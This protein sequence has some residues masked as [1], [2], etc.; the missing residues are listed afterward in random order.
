M[1]QI[2]EPQADIVA[3]LKRQLADEKKARES[4]RKEL[5]ALRPTINIADRLFTTTADVRSYFGGK[6]IAELV[7]MRLAA[8]NK[9]LNRQGFDRLDY[10]ADELDALTETVLQGFLDDRELTT[11]PA[12]GWL[13]RT[14]KMVAPDGSLRQIPYEGQINN[15]AG[16]LADG[17]LVY[18]KKGFKRT[19]PM[20]CPSQDCW[21]EAAVGAAGKG[22]GK[23][24]FVGYCSED[25]FKRTERGAQLPAGANA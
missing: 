17:L 25:H 10:S 2:T 21:V 19:E 15:V 20:L 13:T 23:L 8:E 4:D 7:K 24:A 11:P 12:E 3:D 9:R 14:L 5:E 18:E 6:R 1:T 16:S 22:K